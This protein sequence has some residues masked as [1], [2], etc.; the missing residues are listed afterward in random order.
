MTGQVPNWYDGM[1]VKE[2]VERCEALMLECDDLRSQLEGGGIP[3]YADTDYDE[4]DA[5]IEE[6]R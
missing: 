6:G 3:L 4:L 1:T 2:L 5:E